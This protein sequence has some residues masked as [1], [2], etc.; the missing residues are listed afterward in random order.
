MYDFRAMPS[1][2]V[3]YMERTRLYYEA[4]GF[5]NAYQ[6]AHFDDVPFALPSKPITEL[7]LGLLTTASLYD[8]RASDPREV[9]SGAMDPVPVKRVVGFPVMSKGEVERNHRSGWRPVCWV[10]VRG[11]TNRRNTKYPTYLIP[12]FCFADDSISN[13]LVSRRCCYDTSY[14][15]LLLWSV[16]IHL[17]VSGGYSRYY[18]FDSRCFHSIKS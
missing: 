1:Q 2:P 6:W 17:I 13:T 12:D 3:E 4:Q 11:Y 16:H 10:C 5:E 7:T 8:R 15:F 18:R 9:A 14:L